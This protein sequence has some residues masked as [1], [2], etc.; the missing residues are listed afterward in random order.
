MSGHNKWSQIKYKK[1]IA[2]AKKSA[3]FTRL[4]N[5]IAVSAKDGGGDS[6]T[7]YHLKIAI[8]QA[9]GAGM[10]KDNIERAIKRGT[11]ELGGA[12]IE[13][14]IYEIYGPAGVG[15]LVETASDNKNRTIMEIKTVINKFNAKQAT[16]GSVK[17]QF[18]QKGR[19]IAKYSGQSEQAELTIIDS[20]AQDYS[21]SEDTFFIYT[22]PKQLSIIRAFL[23]KN[24]FLVTESG[25]I[26]EPIN[27]IILD[28]SSDIEKIEK[29]TDTL[30]E[31][32]DVTDVYHNGELA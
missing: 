32:D 1:G 23:E 5:L 14:A 3:N 31:L 30:E 10:P 17:F 19:I 21:A 29:F 27:L 8:D 13:S 7:N 18:S 25:L 11:G 16:S 15:F 9:K 2:D 26:W 20:G 12:Q 4:G 28:S 24:K 6:S 22:E